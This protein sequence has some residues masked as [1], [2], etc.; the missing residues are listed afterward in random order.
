ML[1]GF[2]SL[3]WIVSNFLLVKYFTY[4]IKGGTL[5]DFTVGKKKILKNL[6][7]GDAGCVICSKD[8]YAQMFKYS[9][10]SVSLLCVGYCGG[11]KG[12]VATVSALKSLIGLKLSESISHSFVSNPL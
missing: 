3:F 7:I 1:D 8:T 11:H 4:L 6:L 2:K 12:A 10:S 9:I 5:F